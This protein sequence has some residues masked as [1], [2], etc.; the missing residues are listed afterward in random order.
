MYRSRQSRH[1]ICAC[2]V[3]HYQQHEQGQNQHNTPESKKNMIKPN[4]AH[5]KEKKQDKNQLMPLKENK[6]QTNITS[7]NTNRRKQS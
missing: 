4:I 7:L 6:V 3:L 5:L 1:P 2:V